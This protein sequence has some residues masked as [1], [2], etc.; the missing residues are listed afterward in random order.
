LPS[1]SF[2]YAWAA[3][4]G[5]L[6]ALSFPKYGHP[7]LA[8]IALTP[9]LVA[10]AGR[11][12]VA[13]RPSFTLRRAFL[14]GLVT[15]VVYFIGTLY[16][17]TQVMAVYGGLQQW[18]AVLVNAALIAY[19]A[20]FPAVFGVVMRRIVIAH[21]RPALMAAP[22]VWAATSLAG[23]TSSPDF[24]GCSSATARR[25][26]CPSRSS[27]ACSASTACRCS[28]SPFPRRWPSRRFPAAPQKKCL[29]HALVRLPSR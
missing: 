22:L 3:A 24:H 28:S 4:S 15:G 18:V 29:T 12:R 9:L 26:C 13:S 7:A 10:L 11:S 19:L 27:P 8:W 2:D 6:L 25:R 21:G 14:L 20:L 17:I 5:V 16:W 1:R 23:P